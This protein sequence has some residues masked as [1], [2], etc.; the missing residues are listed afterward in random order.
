MNL[1]DNQ[2][3]F[4]NFSPT[5]TITTVFLEA[6]EHLFF[7]EEPQNTH[8]NL[9]GLP[10]GSAKKDELPI[11]AAIRL[12]QSQTQLGFTSEKLVSLGQRFARISDSDSVIHFFKVNLTEFPTIQLTSHKWISIYALK[13]L[14]KLE[15]R[16]EALD[17]VYRERIWQK[18]EEKN[19]QVDGDQAKILLK[20]GNKTLVFDH[21]RKFVFNLIGTAHSGKATQAEKLENIYGIKRISSRD[22]FADEF[23]VDT[24]LYKCVNCFNTKYPTEEM[25][26]E[27]SIGSMVKRLSIKDCDPG[28]IL[29]DFLRSQT[30]CDAFLKIFLKKEDFHLPIFMDVL[31]DIVLKRKGEDEL[32]DDNFKNFKLNKDCILSSLNKR[33]PVEIFMLKDE[34]ADKVF[35]L[36]SA[37]IQKKLDELAETEDKL[38]EA[39]VEKKLAETKN[40]KK[41]TE[42]KDDSNNNIVIFSGVAIVAALAAGIFF[43]NY[44]TQS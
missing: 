24:L 7:L 12:L 27:I 16:S 14:S 1:S 22:I 6:N 32:F 31:E 25:P 20:K 21:N 18:I 8:S 17:I 36:L 5:N 26:K 43:M 44:K 40:E 11:A 41:S 9:W 3:Y 28:Y 38:A 35:H 39:K 4:P 2:N 34:S 19:A 13:L 23:E 42:T 30:H 29:H 10:G 37:H 15:G 33:D